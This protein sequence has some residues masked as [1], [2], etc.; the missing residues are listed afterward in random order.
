MKVYQM[1]WMFTLTQ[2]NIQRIQ[3]QRK[4]MKGII[5]KEEIGEGKEEGGKKRRSVEREDEGGEKGMI[6][7]YVKGQFPRAN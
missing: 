6:L 4:Q 7:R 1:A 5:G 2:D 3:L